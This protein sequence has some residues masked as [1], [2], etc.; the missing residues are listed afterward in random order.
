MHINNTARFYSQDW[1]DI[2]IWP[3][4]PNTH[5]FKIIISLIH[6]IRP[7]LAIELFHYLDS[8]YMRINYNF[9]KPSII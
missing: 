9:L 7:K 1:G 2:S 6:E 5:P 4:F 3:L 8:D